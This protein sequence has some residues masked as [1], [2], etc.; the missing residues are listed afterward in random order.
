MEVSNSTG[1]NTDYRV[2]SGGGGM[3]M[4]HA[5]P[6]TGKLAP[7]ELHRVDVVHGQSWK[8]EFMIDGTTVASSTVQKEDATVEL[9]GEPGNYQVKVR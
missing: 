8:A 2:G 3:G 9:V 1:Q 4:S 7:G 5:K 6:R